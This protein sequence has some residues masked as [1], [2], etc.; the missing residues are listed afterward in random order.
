MKSTMLDPDASRRAKISTAL[1]PVCLMW[2]KDQLM[3]RA[4]KEKTLL[5][6]FWNLHGTLPGLRNQETALAESD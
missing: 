4:K 2:D 1:F 5:I 3:W 6:R